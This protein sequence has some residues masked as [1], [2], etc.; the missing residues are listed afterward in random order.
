MA[1]EIVKVI[2]NSDLDPA[3]AN[4]IKEKFSAFFDKAHEW[5]TAAKL[6]NITDISQVGEMKKAR[7]ARLALKD[8]RVS[9]DKVRKELKEQ[10]LREGKAIDGV[11]NIIKALIVPIEEYLEKQENFAEELEK[12]E[13]E[14]VNSERIVALQPYVPD[15]SMFNL[16]EM[17]EEGF[18][19]LL[20]SSKIAWEAQKEAERKGKEEREAK[21]KA[22]KEAADEQRKENERLKSE[23]VQRE[24]DLSAEKEKS[25]T[26]RIAR[27]KAEES[28]RKEREDLESKNSQPKATETIKAPETFSVVHDSDE[29]EGRIGDMAQWIESEYHDYIQSR[30]DEGERTSPFGFKEYLV[31]RLRLYFLS[32]Q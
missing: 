4:Y 9:A 11:A 12:A 5:A 32:H 17:T 26:E 19:S 28:L 21:E 3:K 20:K 23:A 24:K 6:I 15:T 22:D 2:E 31:A 10:S 7:E 14:R 25:E 27:E 16:K 18:Q 8:I 29:V 1:N 30:T 13:K